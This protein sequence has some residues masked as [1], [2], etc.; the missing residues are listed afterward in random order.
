[1]YNDVSVCCHKYNVLK[2]WENSPKNLCDNPDKCVFRWACGLFHRMGN[3]D[4]A[5]MASLS[6]QPAF[7][8]CFIVSSHLVFVCLRHL[9]YWKVLL[10]V[11][12]VYEGKNDAK[13]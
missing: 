11:V 6:Q 9:A 13:Q 4:I 7:V 12:A 1:M 2:F 5:A 10:D 3:P 8:S